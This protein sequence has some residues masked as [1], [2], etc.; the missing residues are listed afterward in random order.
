MISIRRLAVVTD[1]EV[2]GESFGRGT[3]R[4]KDE[5]VG[6]EDIVSAAIGVRRFTS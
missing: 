1:V 2:L 3:G 5:G 4:E 6:L